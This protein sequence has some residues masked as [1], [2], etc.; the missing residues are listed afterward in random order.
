MVDSVSHQ[1]ESTLRQ[2]LHSDK[3]EVRF[4]AAYVVGDKKIPIPRAL[5]GVLGDASEDVQQ[6]ARRS[7]ILLG[8][9]ATTPQPTEESTAA[10][11]A[12]KREVEKQ[13][14]RLV[15]LGPTPT[16]SKAAIASASK[17]WTDRWDKNDPELEKLKAAAGPLRKP[18][19]K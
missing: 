2:S 6:M 11:K 7:L 1:D 16:K 18:A 5:I 10:Q 4:A 9:F 12:A 17:K 3:V 19:K 8:T 13:V 14:N 15:K